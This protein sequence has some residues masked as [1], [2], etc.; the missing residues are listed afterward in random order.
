MVQNLDIGLKVTFM[1]CAETRLA[2]GST[3]RLRGRKHDNIT[4]DSIYPATR[5]GDNIKPL[6]LHSRIL[7][8]FFQI[9]LPCQ[10]PGLQT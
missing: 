3:L 10:S 2:S 7:A 9:L 4:C 5:Y 1:L 6:P 8:F